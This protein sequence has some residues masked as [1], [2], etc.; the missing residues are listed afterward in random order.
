M[1]KIVSILCLSFI[2]MSLFAYDVATNL[3]LKGNVKS[4]AIG[5]LS[6]LLRFFTLLDQN[7]NPYQ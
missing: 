4:G 5:R 1:K 6:A 3:Q 2:G 7:T